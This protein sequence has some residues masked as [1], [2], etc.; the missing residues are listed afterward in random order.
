MYP[1]FTIHNNLARHIPP[2]QHYHH[3][4]HILSPSSSNQ[5]PFVITSLWPASVCFGTFVEFSFLSLSWPALL[6]LLLLQLLL[7]RRNIYPSSD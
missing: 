1:P 5:I 4:H 2:H 6:L 7:L 3:R